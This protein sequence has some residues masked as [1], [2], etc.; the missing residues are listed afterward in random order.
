M[1]GWILLEVEDEEAEGPSAEWSS[2]VLELLVCS[3]S[4]PRW[5]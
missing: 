3:P 2:L 5:P 4:D 1:G